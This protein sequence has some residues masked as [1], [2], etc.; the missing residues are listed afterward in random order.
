MQLSLTHAAA[1][2]ADLDDLQPHLGAVHNL[3]ARRRVRGQ[4]RR[5]RVLVLQALDERRDALQLGAAVDELLVA[6]VRREALAVKADAEVLAKVAL[7][8]GDPVRQLGLPLQDARELGSAGRRPDS[9]VSAATLAHTGRCPPPRAMPAT[10]LDVE[11]AL[12]VLLGEVLAALDGV[13]PLLAHVK[14][15]DDAQV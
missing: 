5:Q 14:V 13:L 6:Q 12:V 11:E 10:H 4:D 9:T 15:V 8:R 7:L 3:G 1:R 2:S